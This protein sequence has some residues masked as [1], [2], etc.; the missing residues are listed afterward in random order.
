MTSATICSCQLPGAADGGELAF[1]AGAV[2]VPVFHPLRVAA[3]I[4]PPHSTANATARTLIIM[5]I[6][7]WKS[8]RT[9]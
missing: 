4:P 6:V 3:S 1:P 8:G 9:R 5:V 2:A 7:E